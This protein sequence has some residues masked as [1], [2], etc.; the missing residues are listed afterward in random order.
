MT[1]EQTQAQLETRPSE[2]RSNALLA[3]AFADYWHSSRPHATR[4]VKKLEKA[5]HY[6][7]CR[8]AFYAGA[9][10]DIEGGKVENG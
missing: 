6:T 5:L 2:V 7:S 9:K 3:A 8:D 1:T 4:D 10:A